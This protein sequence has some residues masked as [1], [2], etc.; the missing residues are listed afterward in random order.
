MLRPDGCFL[1]AMYGMETLHELRCSLQLAETEREG[2]STTIGY[3]TMR[4][5]MVKKTVFSFSEDKDFYPHT[6]FHLLRPILVFDLRKMC[7]CWRWAVLEP[8]GYY[9]SIERFN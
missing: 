6:P 8:H 9:S 4:G 3:S 5:R 2:V 1:G 7:F